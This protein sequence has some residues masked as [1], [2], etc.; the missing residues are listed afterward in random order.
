VNNKLEEIAILLNDE[1]KFN[2]YITKIENTEISYS[3]NLEERILYKITEDKN[4]VKNKT[5]YFTILKMVAC[6]V[7]ALIL[8]QTDFIKNTDHISNNVEVIERKKEKE[9]LSFIDNKMNE[10]SSFFMKPIIIEKG[11]K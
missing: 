7:L 10:I 3:R 9:K 4:K 2:E 8:C 1:N 6:M 5:S 11:E